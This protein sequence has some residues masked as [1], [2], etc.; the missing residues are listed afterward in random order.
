MVVRLIEM[1][2]P[3]DSDGSALVPFRSSAARFI[4]SLIVALLV[5]LGIGS[6]LHAEAT[7][8]AS[9]PTA[10]SYVA[11]EH[12]DEDSSSQALTGSSEMVAVACMVGVF[13]GMLVL[14]RFLSTRPFTPVRAEQFALRVTV[15]P[16]VRRL[17]LL[18][19]DPSELQVSRT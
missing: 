16:S 9:A 13:F 5:V 11:H 19:P 6:S 7:A 12:A 10:I 14:G 8:S 1:M 15:R 4:F 17:H 18:R 2:P 3:T